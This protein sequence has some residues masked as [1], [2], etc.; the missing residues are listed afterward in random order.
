M[1]AF[2]NVDHRYIEKVLTRMK[3]PKI[4]VNHPPGRNQHPARFIS[5]YIRASS[6][7]FV[8][9]FGNQFTLSI[10]FQYLLFSSVSNFSW[11]C[12]LRRQ[13][14]LHL[15]MAECV[16]VLMVAQLTTSQKYWP[17]WGLNP[18]PPDRESDALTTI[19]PRRQGYWVRGYWAFCHDCLHL[20]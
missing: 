13:V 3:F 7:F 15:L 9:P 12:L 18:Q 17:G 2:D 1:K 16:Y 5:M 19:L 4:F 14:F 8:G 6:K 11:C 10:F 20:S